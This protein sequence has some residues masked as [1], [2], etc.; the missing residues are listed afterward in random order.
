MYKRKLA[1]E[2]DRKQRPDQHAQRRRRA[3][4]AVTDD[5][6][7]DGERQRRAQGHGHQRAGV[8]AHQGADVFHAHGFHFQRQL[9][10]GEDRRQPLR[11]AGTGGI[12]GVIGQGDKARIAGD[13]LLQRRG[14]DQFVIQVDRKRLPGDFRRGFGEAV[15]HRAG[16]GEVHRAVGVALA[17]VNG[18]HGGRGKVRAFQHG[19]SIL[20]ADFHMARGADGGKV[21]LRARGVGHLHAHARI[22]A[23][24]GGFVQIQRLQTGAQR[25][26]RAVQLAVKV[27]GVRVRRRVFSG[28]AAAQVQPRLQ[29]IGEGIKSVFADA[30]AAAQPQNGD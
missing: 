26:R 4:Q 15:R 16:K 6:A 24:D 5:Q 22:R 19:V 18:A 30:Q 21:F 12:V 17:V 1:H 14:E 28:N 11:G 3:R 7:D 8:F 10:R 9:A 27:L 2:D 29:E 25:L 23:G 13:H 20:V